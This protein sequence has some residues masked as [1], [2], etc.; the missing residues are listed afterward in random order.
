MAPRNESTRPL[1][2]K[3]T[4]ALR[5]RDMAVAVG[6]NAALWVDDGGTSP[7][8]LLW[9]RVRLRACVP[10]SEAERAPR[11]Q[12]QTLAS[13]LCDCFRQRRLRGNLHPLVGVASLALQRDT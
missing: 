4:K 8:L 13:W 7:I 10:K 5:E 3:P 12:F 1:R 6:A 9:N 2:E 11:A